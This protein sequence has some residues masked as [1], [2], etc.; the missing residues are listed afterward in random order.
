MLSSIPLSCYVTTF[1]V[2][3][4]VLILWLMYDYFIAQAGRSHSGFLGFARSWQGKF[5][6]PCNSLSSSFF[7]NTNSSRPFVCRVFP[8]DCDSIGVSFLQRKHSSGNPF[9][10]I[11]LV[12][13][14]FQVA[15]GIHLT[16]MHC[17]LSVAGYGLLQACSLKRLQAMAPIGSFSATV[18]YLV[19]L[20]LCLDT[21]KVE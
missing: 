8:V 16:D 18:N 10:L 17:W 2:K 21:R 1:L 15:L 12:Q 19:V 6:P 7:F 11:L 9:P 20:F 3:L 13:F 14:Y 4:H 5:I